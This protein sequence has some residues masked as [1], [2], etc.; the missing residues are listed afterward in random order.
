MREVKDESA[1]PCPAKDERRTQEE[2]LRSKSDPT[3]VMNTRTGECYRRRD[4]APWEHP[5]YAWTRSGV[6]VKGENG[7]FTTELVPW[8]P[9]E[10]R[11][12]YAD[13]AIYSPTSTTRSAA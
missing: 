3:V 12:A 1:L 7:Q 10:P 13:S 8:E 5:A 11:T 6:F 4:G 9:I 2:Y